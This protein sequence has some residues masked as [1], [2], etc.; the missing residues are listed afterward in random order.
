LTAGAT[1]LYCCGTKIEGADEMTANIVDQVGS[2]VTVWTK[3]GNAME[4]R[5][6]WTLDEFGV[7]V[8]AFDNDKKAVFVPWIQ[9]K[10]I[11]YPV[12]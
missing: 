7:V 5:R 1:R 8:S 6:L 12:E 4:N 11:D 3:D 2:K 9:V 10:Y